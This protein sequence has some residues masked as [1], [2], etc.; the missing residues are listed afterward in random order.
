MTDSQ[1]S[2]SK[3]KRGKGTPAGQAAD[4][5]MPLPVGSPLLRPI[6]RH[7]AAFIAASGESDSLVLGFAAQL[8]AA[9]ARQH[10][11]LPVG[12]AGAAADAAALVVALKRS[13]CV[14]RPGDARPLILYNERLY[15]Q[16]MERAEAMVATDLTQRNVAIDGLDDAIISR[17][18]GLYFD[19]DAVPS[20]G[21]GD[22][23]ASTTPDVEQRIAAAIAV[24]RHL[25]II[26]GG[27]GTGKTTTIARALGVM[28][29]AQPTPLL[30]KLAAPTGKAAARLSDA[31]QA[32]SVDFP[33]SVRAAFPRDVA[34]V[35]RLLGAR[36]DGSFRHHAANPLNL[37]VLIVDEV[38]MLDL[39]L[40]AAIVDALPRHARLILAGDP[41]QLPAVEAGDV[42]RDIAVRPAFDPETARRMGLF[43]HADIKP[44]PVAHR[45]KNGTARLTHSHRF[46]A[47]DGIGFVAACVREGNAQALIDYLLDSGK[48]GEQVQLHSPG[49]LMPESPDSPG[50]Q[51]QAAGRLDPL[52]THY[53][54][55]HARLVASDSVD[56]LLEQF[57]HTRILSPMHGGP[58]GVTALNERLCAG[59]L[60]RD[61]RH[62]RPLLIN[63]NDYV[64]GLY[65]GD[66]GI[67]YE[68][69]G[70]AQVAF[71]GPAGHRSYL[72]SRLPDAE[73][74]FATT[75]HKSQGSEYARVVLVLPTDLADAEL[76]CR[77]LLYTAVTRARRELLIYAEPSTLETCVGR[78]LT[79][80][81]GLRQRFEI[82]APAPTQLDLFGVHNS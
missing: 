4:V 11:C 21:T 75:V 46:D 70:V 79:R 43:V 65:N 33:E 39:Q 50:A 59:V 62:G 52:A 71:P 64:L 51:V 31:M 78:R 28:L 37:D 67:S 23:G 47:A 54:D 20:A 35:H 12:D 3:S 57:E 26:S 68:V 24:S 13:P 40:M 48:T 32:A 7:F 22:P 81:S 19:S 56:A 42:M 5:T 60:G 9:L 14:G 1:D 77:E 66:I 29:E 8:S 30:I 25:A 6:D 73:T 74:C 63:R 34:T 38:S 72:A 16:R 80:Y 18:L 53:A 49:D 27:P 82:E 61:H 58:L 36:L 55:Y 45:L 10:V 44:S 69:D 76:A 15:L 2:N 17:L 41:D